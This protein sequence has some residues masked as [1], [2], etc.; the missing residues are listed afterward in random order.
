MNAA[1]IKLS[2]TAELHLRKVLAATKADEIPV[3]VWSPMLEVSDPVTGERCR[4]DGPAVTLGWGKKGRRAP[5]SCFEICGVAVS[6]LPTTL[7]KIDGK[8]IDRVQLESGLSNG[9]AHWYAL[10]VI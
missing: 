5:D 3:L 9:P 10:R 7:E 4:F 2:P 6:I 1:P 8:T